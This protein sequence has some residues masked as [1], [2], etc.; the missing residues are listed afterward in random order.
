MFNGWLKCTFKKGI[1]SNE[2]VVDTGTREYFVDKVFVKTD[3]GVNGKVR[4]TVFELEDSL[5]ALLPSED[6]TIIGVKES[7]L[8]R[9]AE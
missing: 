3:D 8:E 4:V 7:D 5:G 9:I 6:G 1:F 2:C